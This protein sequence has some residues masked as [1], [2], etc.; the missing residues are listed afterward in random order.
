MNFEV[1]RNR[2]IRFIKGGSIDKYTVAIF[3]LDHAIIGNQ[4]IPT[5]VF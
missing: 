5:A 4:C 3:K 1:T 2:M